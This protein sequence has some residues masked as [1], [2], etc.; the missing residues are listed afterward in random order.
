MS[1]PVHKPA[2][3]ANPD[4]LMVCPICESY[5]RKEEGFTCPRCRRGPLCKTHRV[6]D[7][8]EC[9]GCVFEMTGKEL[10]EL[11]I[12]QK[13]IKS[14]MQ[15]MQ[16]LF[17]VFVILFVSIRTGIPDAVEFLQDSFIADAVGYLGILSVCGYI[18]FFFMMQSQKNKIIETEAKLNKTVIRRFHK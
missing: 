6:P 3:K 8:K 14:A 4:E 2:L 17:I 9:S 5:L 7:R 13:S 15:F 11:K 16:F 10:V 12:Q 1:K 18:F